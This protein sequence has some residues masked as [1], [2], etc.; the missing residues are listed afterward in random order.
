MVLRKR[1]R[2]AGYNEDRKRTRL[3]IEAWIAVT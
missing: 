3:I 2:G 1:L